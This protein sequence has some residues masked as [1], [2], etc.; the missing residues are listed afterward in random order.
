MNPLL[1]AKDT[2]PGNVVAEVPVLSLP[3]ATLNIVLEL[4]HKDYQ[5][6]LGRADL[7]PPDAALE[8]RLPLDRLIVVATV[9]GH[10][11][12]LIVRPIAD[13]ISVSHFNNRV[14][15][16]AADVTYTA[17]VY[18]YNNMDGVTRAR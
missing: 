16:N 6:F 5:H 1:K 15:A 2:R 3:S 4:V 14:T 10:E 13:G 17:E 18:R 8:Y 12:N 9:L 11:S 7:Q